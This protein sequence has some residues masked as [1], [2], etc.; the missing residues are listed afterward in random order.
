VLLALSILAMTAGLLR[1]ESRHE[2][3]TLHAVGATRHIRRA[4]T[5]STCAVLALA[6]GALAVLIAYTALLAGYWPDTD[7]L[8]PVPITHLVT[9]TLGLPLLAG[10]LAWML[11]GRAGA[12][13][14]RR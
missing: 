12:D 1:G 7:R 6:G 4:I 11:G 13:V 2:L 5:A 10:T 8:A 3:H 9:L 14:T